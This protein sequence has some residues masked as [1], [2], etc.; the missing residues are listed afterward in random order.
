LGLHLCVI[1]RDLVS[2]GDSPSRRQP[3]L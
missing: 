3:G 1:V 2:G